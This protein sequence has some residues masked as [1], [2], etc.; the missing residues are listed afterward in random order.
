MKANMHEAKSTLSQLAER[1]VK[2]ERVI[3]AKA[4]EPYVELIRC[5]DEPRPAF[6]WLKG[7]IVMHSDFD[8]NATN[9][10]VAE[11]FEGKV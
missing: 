10:A 3:I 5:R 1:A 9:A 8:S 6:G 11:L 7:Q 2:G 4:G